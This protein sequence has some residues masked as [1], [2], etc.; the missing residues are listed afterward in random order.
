MDGLNADVICLTEGHAG[1]L[2]PGGH[3]AAGQNQGPI[4]QAPDARR[5]LLWSRSPLTEVDQIGD[6]DLPH[7]AFV[8]ARTLTPVGEIDVMCVCIPWSDADMPRFGGSH[9]RWETHEVYLRVLGRMLRE[10]APERPLVVAGDY[11]Q[12]LP[13]IWGPVAM[14]ELLLEALGDL[15]VATTGEIPGLD[16]HVIDHIAHSSE[17]KAVEVGGWPG[18]DVEN[19]PM[20]DHSGV[21]VDFRLR[22]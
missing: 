2:P 1:L 16:A 19:R 5:V 15:S 7:Q 10:R 12:Y 22:D 14:H 4:P 21:R 11:N 6:P 18:R 8:S 3:V 17:L 9:A 20:S 13:R